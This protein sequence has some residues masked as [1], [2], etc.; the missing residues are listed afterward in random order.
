[1]ITSEMTRYTSAL[2]IDIVE[3]LSTTLSTI[4]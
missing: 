2:Q 3:T 4:L 1:M